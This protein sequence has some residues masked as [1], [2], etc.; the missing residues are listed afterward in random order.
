[1]EYNLRAY[2]STWKRPVFNL[3]SI[4]IKMLKMNCSKDATILPMIVE[5]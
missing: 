1:M 5:A 4:I 2:L 3:N